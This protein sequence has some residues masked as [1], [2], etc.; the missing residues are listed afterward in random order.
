MN[1]SGSSVLQLEALLAQNEALSL[2][3]TSVAEELAALEALCFH[4]CKRLNSCAP[5]HCA[6]SPT[7]AQ[8]V[9]R[10]AQA[11]VP[12]VPPILDAMSENLRL[13]AR[14][15]YCQ[16]TIDEIERKLLELIDLLTI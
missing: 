15:G 1:K 4:L 8:T 13:R 16:V 2:T 9:S 5:D 3:C 7:P 10:D 11:A 6:H 12:D 14:L